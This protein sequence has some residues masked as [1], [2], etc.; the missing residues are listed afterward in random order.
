MHFKKYF[1]KIY[2]IRNGSGCY[3]FKIS[4]PKRTL[5]LLTL[6][7]LFTFPFYPW[8]KHIKKEYIVCLD[9]IKEEEKKTL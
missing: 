8:K 9:N 1:I 2:L 5:K 7:A 4:Q 3:D 6:F